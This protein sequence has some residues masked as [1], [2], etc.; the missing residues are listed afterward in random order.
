MRFSLLTTYS[1]TKLTS[2]SQSVIFN[3]I[4]PVFLLNM[5]LSD[6]SSKSFFSFDLNYFLFILRFWLL[7]ICFCNIQ[8]YIHTKWIDCNSLCIRNQYLRNLICRD[9]CCL[10]LLALCKSGKFYHICKDRLIQTSVRLS[11]KWNL[12]IFLNSYDKVPGFW[13]QCP[14]ELYS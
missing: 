10:H 12:I 3:N 7:L 8:T 14:M 9:C 13:Q 6:H 4:C 1:I 5:L 2:N 11:Q